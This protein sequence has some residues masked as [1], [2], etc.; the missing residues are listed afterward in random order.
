MR[1]AW[2]TPLDCQKIQGNRVNIYF[3]QAVQ[4]DTTLAFLHYWGGSSRTWHY[5]T[6]ALSDKFRTIATGHQGR[7]ESHAGAGNY[8]IDTLAADAQGVI[9]APGLEHDVLVGHSISGK[10]GIPPPQRLGWRCARRAS[11]TGTGSHSGRAAR[12]HLACPRFTRIHFGVMRAGPDRQDAV[13][14]RS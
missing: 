4:G 8:S 10:H 9:D 7:G 12:L 3:R 13:R 1:G 5:I 14:A 11:V 2:S 6:E